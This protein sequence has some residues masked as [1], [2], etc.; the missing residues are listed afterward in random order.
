[1]QMDSETNGNSEWIFH[2]VHALTRVHRWFY[3]F[4]M[5]P[6]YFFLVLVLQHSVDRGNWKKVRSA[7]WIWFIG[8]AIMIVFNSYLASQTHCSSLFAWSGI[9]WILFINLPTLWIIQQH[10]EY[11]R[12]VHRSNRA[13]NVA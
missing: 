10:E 13:K 8:W 9:L 4:I 5:C 11:L 2:N 7:K 3:V 1:M 6:I 12:K